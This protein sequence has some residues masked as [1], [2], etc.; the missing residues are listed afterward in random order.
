[1]AIEWNITSILGVSYKT[2]KHKIETG[3]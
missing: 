3:K 2:N 1:M